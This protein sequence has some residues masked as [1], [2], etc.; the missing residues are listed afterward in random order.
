M[1][2]NPSTS[3]PL[4]E[5]PRQSA[6]TRGFSLGAPRSFT[7]S[8]DGQRIV[9]LRTK[10]GDDPTSCLWVLDVASG[11][12]RV[13]FDPL[14]RTGE[15]DETDLTDAE[16]A[17]RERAR[18]RSTG[19][20]G[21]ATDRDVKRA[22]FT[23]SG[24]L[25]L[26]DLV[27]GSARELTAPGSVDD[28]R[29]DG[30]GGQIAFVVDGA[31]YVREL[32]GGYRLLAEEKDPEVTWGLAEF[33][34]AEEMHRFRGHW[35]SPDGSTLAATRVDERPVLEWHIADQTDPAARPRAVRYPQ[36]G[37]ANAIVT[38][39]LFDVASGSRTDVGWDRERFEYL[40]RFEWTESGPPLILVQSRDQRTVQ[41]LEID[42]TSGATALVRERTDPEWV[43]L[44]EDA[45]RRLAGGRIVEVVAD[46]ASDT[47]RLAVDDAF[48]TPEGLQVRDVLD[49]GEGVL[50]CASERDDPTE[51]HLY[52]WTEAEGP[53]RISDEPGVH[54]GAA[55]GGV[56]L[57]ASASARRVGSIVTVRKDGA[58]V[59]T[60]ASHAEDAVVTPKPT[61]VT[62]GERELRAA[63]L[64]PHGEEPSAG[65]KLPVLLDPYGGP[66]GAR[67]LK[68]GGSF[69]TSQWF[70]D[71]GFAVLVIDGRGVDGRGPAWDRMV[72]GD[73]GITLDDQVDGLHAAAERYPFL[74]LGRVAI[75]GWSFGG[76]LSAFAAIRRPD[77]FK[78][79][80]VGAPV[81]EQLL[82]DTHYT[83]R[84]LGLPQEHPEAYEHSSPVREATD[85][86]VPILLIHGLADDNVFVA[87]SLR[88]STALFEAGKHHELV[89]IPNA[90]HL[91]R[92]T[93]IT[94]NLMRV[95][96]DFLRRT[97]GLA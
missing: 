92:S 40:A 94:E 35:W 77:V 60:I 84:Y 67:V 27:E 16:R 39:H 50:F 36:A 31:L 8:P 62:L 14:E 30:A 32:E 93:A 81:T 54:S 5:F 96:L 85:L 71:H 56:T 82:Y 37:T 11:E 18:E 10:A 46:R 91:T 58:R 53:I 23:V 64:T 69:A 28:P 87:N 9:F 42:V 6:R 97:L 22:V 88:L 7:V 38:L 24:R 86:E 90:T 3:D 74:D 12:E 76:E 57:V 48:V 2:A 72:L 25:F 52:R 61:F 43:D 26:A 75:R 68:S 79:A 20:T 33:V 95:Q 41:L 19:V 21:Y 29:L 80:V 13:V 45:P 65:A 17:R 49:A 63:L 66:H 73:F 44:A 15:E 47:Y 51:I 89:L 55:A 34:A 70:A 59:A 78:A 1:S 4:D 83:E